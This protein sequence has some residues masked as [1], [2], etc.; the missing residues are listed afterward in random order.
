[1]IQVGKSN[2]AVIQIKH[3]C[4]LNVNNNIPLSTKE[5]LEDGALKI[6]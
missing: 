6:M 2:V 3:V 5:C 4:T 1:M